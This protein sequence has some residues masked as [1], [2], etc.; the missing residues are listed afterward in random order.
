MPFLSE[1]FHRR[2]MTVPDHTEPPEAS[3]PGFRVNPVEPGFSDR[4]GRGRRDNTSNALETLRESLGELSL[5]SSWMEDHRRTQA[6]KARNHF[7]SSVMRLGS[8]PNVAYAVCLWDIS[9]QSWVGAKWAPNH[10]PNCDPRGLTS[11]KACLRKKERYLEQIILKFHHRFGVACY[12]RFWN[13]FQQKWVEM[14]H[15]PD[16]HPIPD[17][18]RILAAMEIF[19]YSSMKGSQ[20]KDKR[21]LEKATTL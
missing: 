1:S 16:D 13:P 17:W 5:S 9:R 6:R 15:V 10:H 2:I 4:L 7:L 12:L 21:R 3:S 8:V 11:S 20:R 14:A 18:E 19:T